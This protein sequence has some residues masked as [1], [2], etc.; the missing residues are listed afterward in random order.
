MSLRCSSR[1][2]TQMGPGLQALG[3]AGAGAEEAVVHPL[4]SAELCTVPSFS[5]RTRMCS[6]AALHNG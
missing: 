3:M 4:S 1:V 2:R 5:D 6:L